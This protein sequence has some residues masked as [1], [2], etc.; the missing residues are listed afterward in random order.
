MTLRE[1]Y[2]QRDQLESNKPVVWSGTGLINTPGRIFWQD[3]LGSKRLEPYVAMV[4]GI[5]RS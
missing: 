3:A 1:E 4:L 2:R 5:K